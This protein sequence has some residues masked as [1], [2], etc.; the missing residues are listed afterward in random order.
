MTE[1]DIEQIKKHKNL[2]IGEIAR[3]ISMPEGLVKEALQKMKESSK[4]PIYNIEYE[5]PGARPEE[6]PKYLLPFK[7]VCLGLNEKDELVQK[8][9]EEHLKPL[10]LGECVCDDTPCDKVIN[11]LVMGQ[12]GAGKT[13]YVDSF[14]NFLL[15][16]EYY[17]KFRYKLVDERDLLEER[18]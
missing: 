4:K 5:D 14:A 15:G 16:I 8:N 11:L 10:Y 3:L 9:D 1:E 2:A 6:L 12:T 13:T 7:K 17:D 18:K